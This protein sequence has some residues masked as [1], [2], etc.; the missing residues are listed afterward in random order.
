MKGRKII[1]FILPNTH[2]LDLAGPDQVFL[3]SI[4]HDTGISIE[5]CSLKSPVKT[6]SGLQFCNT[7]HFREIIPGNGDYIIIPGADIKMLKA[8]N[9]PGEKEAARWLKEAHSRGV[10]IC[11]VCTGAFFLARAG[12]LD[13]VKC[14]TH[15]KHTGY[16]REKYPLAKVQED[17]LFTEDNNVLTSAG[18]AAGIDMALYIVEK[19]KNEHTAFKVARELVIYRRRNGHES[20]QSVFL[21]YR[22]HIHT[23]IHKVQDHIQENLS[24]NINLVDLADV[25]YMSL[26]SLSRI[27]KKETGI[28]VHE[29]ITLV[30][31]NLLEGIRANPEIS[32][33]QMA[34]LCGLK[35]ER[36]VARLLKQA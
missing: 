29:Y 16:L 4:D 6:S 9:I 21:K 24:G 18:V 25:A 5:Y 17:M 35:S 23:G 7:K 20:Q 27:F 36:Q 19:L 1:F 28:T 30:R 11:S 34:E 33:K 3:E 14:T 15:W 10:Y 2:I 22:N 8:A 31:R 26:R 32:R 13:A 12:L